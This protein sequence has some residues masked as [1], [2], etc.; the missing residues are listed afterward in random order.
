MSK[1]CA[2][3]ALLLLLLGT[4]ANAESPYHSSHIDSEDRVLPFGLS[5][6]EL[7]RPKHREPAIFDFDYLTDDLRSEHVGFGIRFHSSQLL[8]LDLQLDPLTHRSDLVGPVY[9][10][11][12]GAALLTI[13]YSFD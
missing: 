5:G 12:V 11:S 2:W 10:M 9:D 6:W 1:R 7:F 4:T 8:T 13:G 3:I